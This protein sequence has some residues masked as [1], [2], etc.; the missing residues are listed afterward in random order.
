MADS[1]VRPQIVGIGEA[2]L[3]VFPDG[4]EVVGGAPLNFAVHANRLAKVIGKSACIASRTGQD[5]RAATLRGF[6]AAAGMTADFLQQDQRHPTGA[7]NVALDADGQPSYD[8]VEGAAWDNLEWTPEFEALAASCEL[9]CYGSLAQRSRRSRETIEAFVTTAKNAIRLFDVNLRQSYYDYS[10]LRRGCALATV[11]KLNS[12]ELEV[13]AAMMTLR[14]ATPGERILALFE[15]FPIE[16]VILTRGSAGT[17][18]YTASD[19]LEGGKVNA[20]Q[21]Q[22]G[23]DSVGAG[24]AATAAA[25]VAILAGHPL[26]QVVHIAN[27]AGA[28]VAMQPGATPRLPDEIAQLIDRRAQ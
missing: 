15:R 25:A 9:V 13:L 14:G 22:P 26:A 12:D 27:H 16:H 6:L 24:D 2:L 11:L 20:Y 18:I 10:I 3:D 17:A 23:S 4:R 5:S 8:I 7:V 28:Y 21:P 19:R 1:L